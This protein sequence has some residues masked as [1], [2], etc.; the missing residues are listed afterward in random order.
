MAMAFVITA[1]LTAQA[2]DRY[3]ANTGTDF[4]DGGSWI[5]GTA[6]STNDRA[7][8]AAT[9]TMQPYV[10]ASKTVYGLFFTPLLGTN[11]SG[12]SSAYG[13]YVIN[14][15]PGA[16]LTL[17]ASGYN[18]S[19]YYMLEQ[20]T[21]GTNI[22]SV[23]M[24]FLDDG[25]QRSRQINVAS[26]GLELS[27]PLVSGTNNILRFAGSATNS[28]VTL[29]GNNSGFTGG[30]TKVGAFSLYLKS[31][32]AIS[33][34]SRLEFSIHTGAALGN[35]K[36]VNQTGGP[37]VFENNPAIFLNG[38]DGI[39]LESD[40]IIDFGTNTVTF[41]DSNAGRNCPFTINAPRVK[42]GGAAIQTGANNGYFKK[43]SG[44]LEVS[45]PA[46][47]LGNTT[48]ADGVFLARD[49]AAFSPLSALCLDK[50]GTTGG[51]LGLGYGDF[52]NAVGTTAGCFFSQNSGGYAYTGGW[53]AYGA[54]RNVNIG[55]DLR[56]VTNA[57]PCLGHIILGSYDADATVTFQNPICVTN[58]PMYLYS[59]NGLADVDG[60]ISG[61][62]TNL[63]ASPSLYKYG[64]GTLELTA[65]NTMTGTLNIYEGDLRLSGLLTTA[66]NVKTNGMLSG[67]GTMTNSVI[68]ENG[69]ILA[70]KN[71]LGTATFKG[72]LNLNA[73]SI[74]KITLDG[75]NKTGALFSGT[76]KKLSNA[77]PVS[78]YVYAA[79][80][81]VATGTV[82]I[83]DWST[84]TTP[85]VGSLDA[86]KFS[87]ANPTEFTGSFSIQGNAL[88]LNYRNLA[89]KPTV[90][91]IR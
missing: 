35:N 56:P 34:I 25:T 9:P 65:T 1:T 91:V 75:S 45:G 5:A 33:K 66:I 62:L 44:I 47:Y 90:L 11:V 78:C 74:L 46:S 60:R 84:A 55:G 79:N 39:I 58:S 87:I 48:V 7:Y 41:N 29:S 53:A 69:G 12:A 30:F 40:Y 67:A 51:I 28:V 61:T 63:I 4:N 19:S 64:N 81:E 72:A 2:T 27:G 15:A 22:I 26:G 82:K 57:L 13:G 86:T 10:S 21:T 49:P 59:Y 89:A 71:T 3:W 70:F 68:V 16:T 6:P 85:N 23:G 50:N 36:L 83:I 8:F 54:N 76:S 77:G 52:T 88:V 24:T 80:K 42:I 14:G 31:T 20:C 37:L 38:G 73:G 32:N 43:G 17:T 18:N